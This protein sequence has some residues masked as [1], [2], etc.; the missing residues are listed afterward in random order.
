MRFTPKQTWVT[1]MMSLKHEEAYAHP[2]RS[3]DSQVFPSVRCG[4]KMKITA[5][6]GGWG[7]I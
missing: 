7:G 4:G 2:S 5:G 3:E 1:K 6:F